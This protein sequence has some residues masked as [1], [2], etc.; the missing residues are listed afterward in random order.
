MTKIYKIY[1]ITSEVTG[2]SYIG[3]TGKKSID[4]RWKNHIMQANWCNL[5]H[6]TNSKKI[7]KFYTS[8]FK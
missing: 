2:L 4:I 7:R 3:Y 5:K 6:Q 8:L 1:K